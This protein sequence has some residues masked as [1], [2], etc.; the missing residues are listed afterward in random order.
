MK[1]II[2]MLI[3]LL[4]SSS[5]YAGDIAR[6]GT[7]GADY[8]LIPVSARGIATGGAF[9]AN[10][11][12]LESVYYNPAGLDLSSGSEFMFSYMQYLADIK[13]SYFGAS[14]NLGDIG[15]VGITLKSLGFGDID[16]TTVDFPDGTGS[17]YSPSYLTLGLTY[18]KVIT[19]RV[20]VG[21]NLKILSESIQNV[22][23][24]G[25]AIDF[26]VQYRFTPELMI[27]A[28]VMNIGPNMQYNGPELSAFTEIPGSNVGSPGGQ[29]QIVTEQ[30]QIPSY[31]LLSLAYSI[32][33]NEQNNLLL[34]STF[35]ANNSLED[36]LNF[37]LEYGF[38]NNFFVRG[39]YNMLLENADQNI[40]GLT[41]GAGINYNI[42]EDVGFVFDYAFRDVKDFPTANH[43]FTIK[44]NFQ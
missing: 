3:M 5:V 33:F 34:A 44:L 43:V 24:T 10:L 6:K 14:T 35:T 18:S 23:A 19:D 39:G 7:T 29:Y 15:S 1:K 40:F 27:G 32:D 26:G 30:F 38:L 8:L 4:I 17:T 2:L 11:T 22:S 28:A 16:I 31:F 20:A 12:G 25:W 42:G 37:G 41:F 36:N 21:T 9:A 13:I